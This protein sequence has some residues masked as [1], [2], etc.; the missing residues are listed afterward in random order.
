MRRLTSFVA[1]HA[2]LSSLPP[3]L[4]LAMRL[5]RVL[6]YNVTSKS[7]MAAYNACHQDPY[8]CEHSP[9]PWSRQD[10][11]NGVGHQFMRFV[12]FDRGKRAWSPV[13]MPSVGCTSAEI[14]A[15]FYHHEYEGATYFALPGRCSSMEFDAVT[16]ECLEVEP[17]GECAN[18]TAVGKG[19]CTWYAEPL[20]EVSVDDL[21]GFDGDLEHFCHM[22]GREWI[23]D[24]DQTWDSHCE[25]GG[26]AHPSDGQGRGRVAGNSP[27]CFWDGRTDTARNRL[28]VQR[29]RQLFAQKYPETIPADKPPPACGF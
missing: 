17:G 19:D 9:T 28:R 12:G 5:R 8:G 7:T 26:K 10:E 23:S 24:G 13:G 15:S 4:A 21:T 2:F 27:T 29:L 16:E 3:A 22:G 14:N 20:G 6:R 1:L 25:K 11:P 18:V